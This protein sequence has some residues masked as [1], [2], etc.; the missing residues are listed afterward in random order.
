MTNARKKRLVAAA[1][2]AAA[3]AYCPYS[4]FKVGAA[5]LD[6]DNR[7]HTGCNVENAS[8]GLTICAERAAVAAAV[9]SGAGTFKALAVAAGRGA[10][11]YPCGAC[12]QVLAEFCGPETPVYLASLD[13]PDI[14]ETATIGELLPH[15]FRLR[16]RQRGGPGKR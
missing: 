7:I 4:G 11:V 5:L 13:M 3:G 8:Y 1:V 9:S 16:R 15:S 12:R 10:A 2:K 14:V 6:A